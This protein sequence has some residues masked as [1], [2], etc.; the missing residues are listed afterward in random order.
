MKGVAMGGADI[1]PGVSGGTIALIV[2]IYEKLLQAIQSIDAK[3]IRKLLSFNIKEALSIIHIRFLVSLLAGIGTA[4]VGLSHVIHIFLNDFPV[5]TWA[6]FFGLILA[7]ILII[8]K[9]ITNWGSSGGSGFL[10]G[11][12]SGYILV[13]LIPVQTPETSWFIF[14]CGMIAICAMILPGISGAFLLLVLGKY[15]YVTSALKNPFLPS[16]ILIII[17]FGS[18]ALIGILAFS[19]LLNYLL[20]NYHNLTIAILT[21]LMLGS[22][23]KVWP[24]KEILE[25]K[26]IRGKIH[27]LREANILPVSYDS[28]FLLA[29]FLILIGFILVLGLDKIA[30]N[31]KKGEL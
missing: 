26:L 2:G 29:I 25:T 9:S 27:V 1:I 7:S 15:E 8:G 24:W 23:R 5:Q 20:K 22:L 4:V 16:S 14:L 13:G 6:F 17:T 11:T 3:F 28:T 10:F 21:G 18:G 30:S 19:R 31:E 12:I